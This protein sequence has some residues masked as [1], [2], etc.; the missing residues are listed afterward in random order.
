MEIVR[1]YRISQQFAMRVTNCHDIVLELFNV[2]HT[3]KTWGASE[4]TNFPT[5]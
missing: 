2:S 4:Y 5:V 1:I 3:K